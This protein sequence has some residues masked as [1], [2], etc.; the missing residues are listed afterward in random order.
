MY[1]F[2]REWNE[3]SNEIVEDNWNSGAHCTIDAV[4]YLGKITTIDKG[5]RKVT[6]GFIHSSKICHNI[7]ELIRTGKIFN[8]SRDSS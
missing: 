3:S 7:I 5:H 4:Y 8:F 2:Y 6:L 1:S